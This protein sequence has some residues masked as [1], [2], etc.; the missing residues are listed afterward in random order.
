MNNRQS[1][2]L[3]R[4]EFLNYRPN[5][6]EGWSVLEHLENIENSYI[7]FF[8]WAKTHHNAE[9][10][11]VIAVFCEFNPKLRTD[12]RYTVRG[13]RNCKPNENLHYFTE[14]KDAEAYLKYVIECTDIWLEEINSQPYIDAYNAKIAKLVDDAEKR[15]PKVE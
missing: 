15:K 2:D 7:T 9:P 14:L 4:H 3:R 12:F 8:K 5:L 1:N 10:T 13:G 11:R 6:P